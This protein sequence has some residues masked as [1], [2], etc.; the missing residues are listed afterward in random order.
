[1]WC[2][3]CEFFCGVLRGVGFCLSFCIIFK[4]RGDSFVVV[5]AFCC[6]LLIDCFLLL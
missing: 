3:L 6:F 4:G 2:S 1:M 5:G